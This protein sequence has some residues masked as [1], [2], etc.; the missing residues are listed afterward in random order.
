MS[1]FRSDKAAKGTSYGGNVNLWIKNSKTMS[2]SELEAAAEAEPDQFPESVRLLVVAVTEQT[3][4]TEI[5]L[6]SA[7]VLVDEILERGEFSSGA[8]GFKHALKSERFG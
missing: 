2:E 3:E 5:D 6:S 8:I 1:K 4:G 7:S